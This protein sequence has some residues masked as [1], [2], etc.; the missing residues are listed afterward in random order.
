LPILD[1]L[2]IALILIAGASI[3]WSTLKVGISPMPSSQKAR[4]A[5]FQLADETGEGSIYDL[6][7]G[8]GHLVIRLAKRYPQRQIVAYELS[9]LPWLTTLLLRKL[10]GL[11]NLVVHREDFLSA[12]LSGAS[13][14][15][16]YLHAPTMNAINAKLGQDG[17]GSH[18]LI[19]HNFALPSRTA[20]KVVK[21][22]DFYKSPIYLYRLSALNAKLKI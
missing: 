19:S 1:I 6:G 9:V 13:V 12:D 7:S 20:L 15:M 3:V 5:M 4:K 10:L 14:L 18:Y 11:S 2:L 21:L 17:G 8:W 22:N 16:C